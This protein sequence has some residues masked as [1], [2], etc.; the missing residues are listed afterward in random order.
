MISLNDLV[1]SL[2]TRQECMSIQGREIKENYRKGRLNWLSRKMGTGVGD[3]WIRIG[4][5][6]G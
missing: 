1:Y 3:G 4:V 2:G 5:E 6:S